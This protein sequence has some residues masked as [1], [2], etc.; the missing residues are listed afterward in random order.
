MRLLGHCLAPNSRA[1]PPS[2]ARSKNSH[3]QVRL[4]ES[5]LPPNVKDKDM[6]FQNVTSCLSAVKMAESL[7]KKLCR[8]RAK[9]LTLILFD[10]KNDLTVFEFRTCD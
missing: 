1:A 4:I 6:F 2:G 9:D 3:P 10:Q 7:A 5:H 8:I